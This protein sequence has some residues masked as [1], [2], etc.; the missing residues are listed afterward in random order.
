MKLTA[1]EWA[2]ATG[3]EILAGDPAAFV[4]GDSPG[5]LSIDS[6][7]V[8]QGQ[9]FIALRG[10]SGRDGHEFLSNAI[11]AGAAGVIVSDREAYESLVASRLPDLNALLVGDTTIA[12]A[13]A[14]RA[15]LDKF[16]PFVIAITGTVGKTSVKENIAHIASTRWPTLKNAHNWNTEIGVPLTIF[17]LGPH[18]RVAVIECATRGKGQIGYLSNIVKP[19]VAAITSIGPGHLS[20]FGSIERVAE[21]K[22]EI[23]EGLK[24]NGVVVA[25]GGSIYTARFRGNHRL[26]TFG[27]EE[28]DTVHPVDISSDEKSMQCTIATPMGSFAAKI[29]GIG[30]ADLLN[31]LCATACAMEIKVGKGKAIESPTLDEIADAINTLPST[32][33][34]METIVRPSG[35]EVIFDAYNSNPL[36][37]RNALEVL[38]TRTVLSDGSPVLRRVAVLG[39]ML[40]LGKDQERYHSDAGRLV[41]ELGIDCVI[42]VGEL[43]A[44]IR[45]AAEEHRGGTIE[46]RHFGSTEECTAELSKWLRPGDLVLIK[47][48]RGLAFERML[49]GGW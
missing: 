30:L 27:L 23:V 29:P 40:E 12:L 31:T 10:K 33:G 22:W 41:A 19:D 32:P 18:H 20:E 11:F 1:A 24:E 9:W 16:R 48:S 34:R 8:R 21:G 46:G 13:D 49:K 42:T 43:A 7:S 37:L 14:A 6:R 15:I 26:I 38:A 35:I 3:G 5:G 17:D 44:F 2:E 39:D 45:T 47:A 36:S 28:A 25:P 4:G